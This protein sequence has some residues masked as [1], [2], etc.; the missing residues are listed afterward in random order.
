MIDIVIVNYNAGAML[1]QCLASVWTHADGIVERAVVVD[2]G[3]TD[4]SLDGPAVRAADVVRAGENLGF[5]R[6]C[7][8]G[9]A[10]GS[11]EL[12][13]FLN[14]DAELRADTLAKVVARMAMPDCAQVGIAG[15]QLV[16][17]EGHVAR[18]CAR[19]PGW[20]TFLG[21]STGLGGKLPGLPAHFMTDFDHLSTREV[22]EVIGAFFLVRRPVFEA[23]GGF[24]ERF[25]VYYEELDFAL[26]AHRAGW[27]TLYLAEAQALH[28]GGGA[29]DRVKAHRLFFLLRSR[30]LYAFK[31]FGAPA[32]WATTAAAVA[33]EPAA[34]LV[35]AALRGSADEARDTIA[36]AR[37]LWADLPR[38]LR[39]ARRR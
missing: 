33:A 10:R 2:N 17:A 13:L 8:L 27:R 12:V 18:H 22:D 38:T 28:H 15:V 26:R 14:P 1:E 29:S 32:A 3:S 4:G 30:V 37:M 6:A 5:A 20:R 11:A 9:A 7:N 36:G 25:F 39:A 23:L 19:F 34:R 16:D 21:A 24:D 35:R 31:H